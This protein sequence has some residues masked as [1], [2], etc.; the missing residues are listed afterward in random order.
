[1]IKKILYLIPLFLLFLIPKVYALPDC[2]SISSAALYDV[3]SSTSVG[4]ISTYSTG[5]LLCDTIFDATGSS[6]SSQGLGWSINLS[7]LNNKNSF[8]QLD[9]YMYIDGTG[10]P[11]IQ[12]SSFRSNYISVGSS[13]NPASL[14]AN[15]NLNVTDL[16]Y[17]YNT[18]YSTEFGRTYYV[19]SYIFKSNINFST[20]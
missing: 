9:V 10:T 8:Y 14:W 18:Y 5:G 2:G 13:T 17:S 3:N 16:N 4:A 6:S 11:A 7:S 1:M 12:N 20:S 15:G 19:A